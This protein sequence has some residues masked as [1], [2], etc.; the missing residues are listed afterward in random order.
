M[1]RPVLEAHVLPSMR[2]HR[3][4]ACVVEQGLFCVKNYLSRCSPED[5]AGLLPL[6]LPVT[7]DSMRDHGHCAGVVKQALDCVAN[8][9]VVPHNRVAI[10]PA[11]PGVKA[12]ASPGGGWG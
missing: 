11:I 1:V 12:G 5:S 4:E 8:A 6:V 7:L 2:A 3:Q 9:G 10:L